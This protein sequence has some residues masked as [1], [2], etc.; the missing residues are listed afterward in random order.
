[1]S[2]DKGWEECITFWAEDIQVWWKSVVHVHVDGPDCIMAIN[3]LFD[4]LICGFMIPQS[5]DFLPMFVF[6][7]Y[8]FVR[9]ALKQHIQDKDCVFFFILSSFI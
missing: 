7:F 3:E 2:H 8:N 4:S 1:M 5:T 9:K 6:C